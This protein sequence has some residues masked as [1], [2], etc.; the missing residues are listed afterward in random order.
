M[1]EQPQVVH[2]KYGG[3]VPEIAS[4]EHDTQIT[5]IV[6]EAIDKAKY[7]KIL[8][9]PIY[10]QSSKKAP[11]GWCGHT[12]LQM[13]FKY[14]GDSYTQKEINKANSESDNPTIFLEDLVP[15]IEKT[16]NKSKK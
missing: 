13:I 2:S 7:K 10:T 15:V 4:R 3:V 14:Y 11:E 12:S 6:K 9:V 16:T 1:L 5:L 8:D